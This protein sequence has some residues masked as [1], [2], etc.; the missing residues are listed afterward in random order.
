MGKPALQADIDTIRALS[1]TLGMRKHDLEAL[2]PA[3]PVRD[4]GAA[5]PG[6]KFA[7]AVAKAG[8]PVSR[9]YKGMAGQVGRMATNSDTA[10]T[11]Y[12]ALDQVSAA[13]FRDYDAGR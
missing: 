8:D 7:A 9:A 3:A 10:A 1:K 4:A 13:Q 2:D 6:S 5:M 12:D 11:D